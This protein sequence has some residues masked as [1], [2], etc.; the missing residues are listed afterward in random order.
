MPDQSRFSR[1]RAGLLLQFKRECRYL[2]AR[3]TLKGEVASQN[4][5]PALEKQAVKLAA[6]LPFEVAEELLAELS[7]LSLADSRIWQLTQ[8]AGQKLEQDCQQAV[9]REFETTV[10]QAGR[11]AGPQRRPWGQRGVG[12]DGVMI[13]IRGEGYKETKLGCLFEFEKENEKEKETEAAAKGEK[14]LKP[15]EPNSVRASE[16]SYPFYLGG[17]HEFGQRRWLEANRREWELALANEV[18]GYGAVWVW[19]VGAE[20]FGG[21]V[22]V[23][24]WYHAKQHLWNAA[25]LLYG[26]GSLKA[27]NFVAIYED[28]LYE[29]EAERVAAGI[30]L[31][32]RKL[33]EAVSAEKAE[34]L[35]RE[36]NYFRTNRNRMFYRQ[37]E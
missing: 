7:G 18:V 14:G 10:A 33:G 25:K 8:Q 24:D 27:S 35:E 22:E 28:K 30:E 9:K 17:P 15:S 20:H 12:M 13:D 19:N 37:P 2:S 1:I 36:A 32:L 29:G 31:N 34:L 16:Q 21:A 11:G 5:S 26:E 23:V 6:W 4:L 3:P